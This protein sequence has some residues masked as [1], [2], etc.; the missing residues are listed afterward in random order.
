MSIA[1]CSI[2][3]RLFAGAQGGVCPDCLRQQE[4]EFD[5]IRRLLQLEPGLSAEEVA[6][7]TG[8]KL[9]RILQFLRQGRLTVRGSLHCE[10]CGIPISSGRYCDTCQARLTNQL[11]NALG[12]PGGIGLRS[13]T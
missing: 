7:R 13:R 3:G 11:K 9:E 8:V 4:E 2:C 1:N 5:E 6:N 12:K 10:G